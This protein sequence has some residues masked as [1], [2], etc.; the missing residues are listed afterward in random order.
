MRVARRS[1]WRAILLFSLCTEEEVVLSS[2]SSLHTVFTLP[3]SIISRAS[4]LS[5][6]MRLLKGQYTEKIEKKNCP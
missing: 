2:V 5:L 3:V 4:L 1:F 6:Q